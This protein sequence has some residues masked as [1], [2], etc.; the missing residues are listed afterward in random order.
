MIARAV[1]IS[2]VIAASTA[3]A[4]PQ[5]HWSSRFQFVD[6]DAIAADAAGNSVIAGHCY[7]WANLG[8]GPLGAD[9]IVA[10]KFDPFGA[11][12]WSRLCLVDRNW[13]NQQVR[14]VAID[15]QGNVVMVGR[16]TGTIDFGGGPLNSMATDIFVAKWDTDGNHMWSKRFGVTNSNNFAEDVAFDPAGNVIF[17]GN[18][19][20]AINFGGPGMVSMGG[21]DAFLAKLDPAGNHL[22]SQHLAGRLYQFG[23]CVAVDGNGSIFAGGTYQ[24]EI[25]IGTGMLLSGGEDMF[26]ARFD[27]DGAVLDRRSYGDQ[28]AQP[29][30]SMAVDAAGNLFA[31]GSFIGWINFDG[32]V[33]NSAPNDTDSYVVSFDSTLARRWGVHIGGTREQYVRAIAIDPAGNAG[34]IGSFKGPIDLGGTTHTG[35]GQRDVFLARLDANGAF[36]WAQTYGDYGDD[37]A[38]G[39]AIDAEGN[40]LLTGVFRGTL[41]FGGGALRGGAQWNTFLARLGEGSIEPVLDI[42]LSP[43]ARAIEARWNVSSRRPIDRVMILRDVVSRTEPTIVFVG[44]LAPGEQ[45]YV[46]RDV[47]AGETYRYEVIA[48]GPRDSQYRSSP[49]TATVPVFADYLAQNA[50]NPFLARASITYSLGGGRTDVALVIYDVTGAQVRRI[51]QGS[52]DTGEYVVEWN[53]RDD[54][55]R[56]VSSGVYFYRL[57]GV[58]GVGPRKMVLLK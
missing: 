32:V 3:A 8:G 37:I 35:V 1:L 58:S 2:C 26:L 18:F 31:T 33:F 45:S 46:D 23:H 21:Q 12:L 44:P 38:R 15:A 55:G 20:R 42:A 39:L 56:E 47:V 49:A 9:G 19:S 40:L 50:P 24:Q 6:V 11:L 13:T 34:I 4:D 5:H 41:D 48:V 16:F 54:A 27:A 52:R 51:P 43:R 36:T 28:S 17:I 30:T 57:D 22:W 29:F 14:S 7:R 10:A 53:G 25:Y